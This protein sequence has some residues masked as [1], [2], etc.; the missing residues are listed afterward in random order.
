MKKSD[1]V[2][3]N[4][5]RFVKNGMTAV[6]GLGA[7]SC[8]PFGGDLLFA[9]TSHAAPA[10]G[11]SELGVI[12][13]TTPIDQGMAIHA[14]DF[15]I[16]NS[17]IAASF[18]VGSNNYW[19]MTN[20]SILDIAVRKDGK[21][22]VDLV[23]DVEF[24][25]DLW[26]ATGSYNGENLLKVPAGDITYKQDAD[27]IVVTAKTRYWTAGHK[28]P[29]NVTIQY[30]LG[31]GK[32]YIGL[33]TTV[34]NPA[35]N[36]PYENL[37]S[38]YS[39]STLAASMY[40]PFGFYPD[41]KITGIGVGA[42]KDVNE[43]FGNFVVTYGKDY[44]V[45]VQLDGANSYKGSSGYK[46]VYINRTIEPGKSYVYDGE[47][48]VIDKGETAPI[49]ERCLEKNPSVPAATVKGEV[50]D[51]NGKSVPGAYIIVSQK[52]GYKETV[53]SHG[54]DNLK[55]DIMQPL[56]WKIAD[57]KGKF[58]MRLPQ[59]DYEMHVEAMGFTPSDKQQIKLTGDKALTFSVKDGA[60]A[61]F[62]VK[63]ENGKAIP[64]KV[65][66][67]GIVSSVKTLGGTVF[68]SDP[69]TNEVNFNLAAPENDLTFTVTHASDFETLPVTV[70]RKVTP[71]E[72]FTQDVTVPTLIKPQ[73]RKW[74]SADLHE[75][76]DIGDG[77]TAP[78]ELH[79]GQLAAG[80]NLFAISDHDSVANDAEM[81]KLSK[82]TGTPFIPSLE[83]SPGWGHWGILGVDYTKTP[84]SPNLTP[85]E[86]IKAGHA[87]GA[88]VVV[89]HPYTDYGFFANREGVK[90]GHDAGSEDFDLLEIQSTIN[91]TDA[92]NIDKRAL[93]LAMSFWD[94][95][96][97]K[98]L[99]SGSDQHDVTSGLYPGII[100]T[101]A[102]VDGELTPKKFLD[103][104][105]A[106][107]SYVTMG[108]IVTPAAD[109]MFG[110]T[111]KVAAGKPVKL[112]TEVQS[113]HGVKSIEVVSE[114][115]VLEKK[116]FDNTKGPVKFETSQTPGKDTWYNFVIIDGKGRYAV[117]NP[118]WVK[119]EK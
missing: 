17:K 104:L 27:K 79:K 15:T 102:L 34:E 50:K 92:K 96:A 119:V 86:I 11:E 75:H 49:L 20:G 3:M 30:T 54:A 28:L 67:S 48:L 115:K 85:A 29:L 71:R 4:R 99:V 21:F 55:K 89:N 10:K 1:G 65:V 105:K 44:A 63:D 24:L 77:A 74:Y 51:S 66:V 94:K 88:T 98:Y 6:V 7:L 41:V 73:A 61:S 23:N 72:K 69:K 87:M 80:L 103:S 90:G 46:D 12:V 9:G 13:G 37:Y 59:G 35:G 58:S 42:D 14:N 32:N 2:E 56:V 45:S 93:D 8:L 95:G 39:L 101:Y 97:K 117:T 19:N 114:G 64:A 112:S 76:S 106:G 16:Y 109:S 36:E 25:N 33:K 5:R 82:G 68:F 38:G 113:V 70:T 47:I 31:A 78:K 110:S 53:K 22:G 107:S 84:I 26:T 18:A 116:E 81:A 111:R 52:G 57:D 62:R 108:P 60:H 83:V 91:L 43:Q 40:G 100:R 118:V